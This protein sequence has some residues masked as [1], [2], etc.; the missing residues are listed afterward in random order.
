MKKFFLFCSCSILLVLA[1]LV[2]CTDEIY[3]SSQPYEEEPSDYVKKVQASMSDFTFVDDNFGTRTAIE[4]DA[5]NKSFVWSENDTIGI[6]PNMGF[7]VAFPMANGAGTTSAVFDGGG[8]GLKASASYSAYCPLIGQFYLDK[9][10]IPLNM[11]GQVQTQNGNG[12]HISA[13]DYMAAINAAVDE[14]GNVAFEFNHLVGILHLFFKVPQGTYKTLILETSGSFVTEATLNLSDGQVTPKKKSAIQVLS[15]KDLEIKDEGELLE[16]YMAILPTDLT[17]KFLYAKIYDSDGVCYTAT[18][19]G[20]NYEAGTFYNIG[21]VAEK[22]VLNTGLPI[23]L[24]N[25]PDNAKITSKEE[26]MQDA[27]ITVLNTDGSIDYDNEALQIRGRGNSTWTQPKK[28]YALKLDSKAEIL[29]MPKHKRWCLLADYFDPGMVRNNLAYYIGREISTLEWS[30]RTQE[31]ELVLNGKYNGL[32]LLCEQIKIDKN[33]VNVGDDGFIMEIDVRASADTDPYF[34]VSHIPQPIA[35]K[36]YDEKDGSIE[37]IKDYVS[38]VDELLFSDDYLDS[39]T[40]WKSMIDVESFVEWYLIKE[41]SKD[42]DAIFY[43]SCYMN[44]KRGGKLKMGP[45]W[46]FDISMGNY[47]EEG[48]TADANN[49]EGFRIKNV[50]WFKRMFTDSDFVAL[51]KQRFEVYY[52]SQEK[53]Y[54]QIDKISEKT[55]DAYQGEIDLWRPSYSSTAFSYRNERLDYLKNWLRQRFEWLKTEFGKM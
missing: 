23:V 16:V 1:C 24:I 52:N 44:L 51:V 45:L 18:L 10:K 21:R 39:E 33:R 29:G 46:D 34:S 28:P 8:W 47:F 25:T 42:N 14:N 50:A 32:Y 31:V 38:R 36:D 5:T 22:D 49:P 3:E 2:S 40:G 55:H 11:T 26:W 30:P 37:Y 48:G 19:A 15:L 12:D 7:Q 13:Y 53:I 9:T 20:K 41:I 35:V 4:G 43:S 6:F 54:N 17:D 27:S